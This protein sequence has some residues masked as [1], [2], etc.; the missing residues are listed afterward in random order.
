MNLT[1]GAFLCLDIG[2]SGVHAVAVRVS[3]GRIKASANAF[4][5]SKDAIWALKSAVDS[6]EEQIGSRFDSAFVTGN[7]GAIKS[8]IFSR[9]TAWA[10]E[11][12]ITPQDVLEQVSDSTE[13]GF[14][15]LHIIP[16][17]Y[18]M[19]GF[20]NIANVVGQTDCALLSVF[21][22]ISYSDEG[23]LRA[24]SAL[25]G[26]H[27]ESDGFFDPSF[28]LAASVRESAQA[29]IFIDFGAQF[30]S[31][32]L[33]TPRGPML[34]AKVPLGGARITK[35]IAKAF[36]LPV[37]EAERLKISGMTLM[38]T[39]MDRFTPSDAKHDITRFELNEV[40]GAVF[41]E[42]LSQVHDALDVGIQK[43]NPAKLYISGGGAQISGLDAAL[44]KEFSMPVKN[45]GTFGIANALAEFVWNTESSRI[46]SYLA[47][48]K[49]WDKF[50]G[51]L[52]APLRWRLKTGRKRLVPI[53]PSTLVLDMRSGATYAKFASAN[54]SM[55]HVDVMDGFYVEKIASGI[56]ELRF[57]RAHTK[58]HLHVHL[59]TENPVSWAAEAIEAGADTIIV[60]SGTNGVVRA[61]REIRAMGRRAGIAL[62][63][64]TP[65]D[66]IAPVLRE[67]DEVMVMSVVPGAS[68]QCFIDTSL[69]RI[70]ALYNTRRR[71]GLN[72]KISV[73][74][75]INPET[76]KKCWA[77]GADLLVAGSFLASAPDFAG[78]VQE[79]IGKRG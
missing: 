70:T 48:R 34:I 78:A 68:G 39:D 21:H 20:H 3:F 71:H 51:F 22:S 40:T 25:H 64:N 24:K 36:G 45:L 79:L 61:L 6:L 54:I 16:L 72:F 59:M 8:E 33:W 57:I 18:D 37:A 76:A 44:E 49:K 30:T 46:S 19:S 47:R 7:F 10:T 63:P 17:R 66:V 27:L 58:S 31:V 74:G 50:F 38:R 73:D 29:S 1:D 12:K 62:H 28:I 11:H 14:S 65:L 9:K 42:I 77:A 69:S 67:I 75:G 23:L 2:S 43:Y 35:E 55:I 60:S 5:E 26:A 4:A 32:S 53:M 13:D 52:F 41:S 56:D 15:I